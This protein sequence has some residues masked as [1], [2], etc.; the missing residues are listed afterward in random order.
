ML[1]NHCEI[2][3]GD[4]I[5]TFEKDITVCFF[6][7]IWSQTDSTEGKAFAMHITNLGSI[8]EHGLNYSDHI[9]T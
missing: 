4:L 9:N 3:Y 6:V 7:K 1:C 5:F 8:M 2:C